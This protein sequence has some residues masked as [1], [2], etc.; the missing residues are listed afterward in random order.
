MSYSVVSDA[1][2]GNNSGWTP[3]PEVDDISAVQKPYGKNEKIHTA[4]YCIRFNSN[5][6]DSQSS[7]A[8]GT[9]K[10]NTPLSILDSGGNNS[11]DFSGFSQGQRIDLNEGK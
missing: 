7:I 4:R 11:L 3:V 5:S 6:R 10:L 8:S 1:T 2:Q 9:I